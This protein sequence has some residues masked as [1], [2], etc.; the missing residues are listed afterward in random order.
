MI[1]WSLGEI[2]DLVEGT[3]HGDETLVVDG[4]ATVD[5][6]HV[7]PGGLFAALAG[8]RVD[9]HDYA[10]T[11][12]R[13]GAAAV[14]ASRVVDP[15]C[16][17]VENVVTALTT[18]ARESLARL[19]TT[20]VAITGSAGKT[21]VKDLLA[22]VLEAEGP[23]VAPQGSFNNELGVPLTVL[24]ADARTRFLVVEMGA[25]GIGHIATLCRI[26]PPDVGVVLNVGHAHVGEFGSPERTAVAK[27]ELVEALGADGVAVLNGDDPLVA[28]MARRTSAEVVRFGAD[29]AEPVGSRD[30]VIGSI[31]VDSGGEPDAELS[32]GGDR[33]AVHVPQ[34]GRH[35][36][37]NGAACLAV[38]SALGLD[39]AAVA[40]RLR[41]ATAR[42]PMR[43]ARHVRADGLIVID[44][45]YNANPESVAAALEALAE[46][47]TTGRRIAVLG[48]MLELGDDA[49]SAHVE[50]GRR[51]RDLGVDLVL[52]VGPGA[53]GLAE[54]A[55]PVGLTVPDVPTAVS[56]LTARLR[57][58]D[59]VLV[60][61]SRGARLERIVSELTS[62]RGMLEATRSD[63]VQ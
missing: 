62:D 25:R 36:M 57:P 14:L 20:V 54:G 27:G 45:A 52:A 26:A 51:A 9:G 34:I 28:P 16:V 35:Q 55:G 39:A 18:L 56:T 2:A 19:T 23:T 10:A 24:R 63:P 13:A 43:M 15:P 32:I 46:V 60:K 38:A 44:D 42:S 4:P 59:V 17:V 7:A 30:V 31:V 29:L 3:V 61:A 22:H 49:E 47:E 37:L 41:T 48:E 40:A 11:A 21:S 6:R 1:A 58:D 12:H 53:G 5:S 50:T 8:E 33:L